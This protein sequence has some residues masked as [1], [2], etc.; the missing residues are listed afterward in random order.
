MRADP[1]FKAVVAGAAIPKADVKATTAAVDAAFG[2]ASDLTPFI[3]PLRPVR[4]IIK[5]SLTGDT[6]TTAVDGH[7]LSA[8]FKTL[9]QEGVPALNGMEGMTCDA[10]CCTSDEHML[11]HNNLFLQKVCLEADGAGWATLRSI[12]I[13]DGQ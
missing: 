9:S 7:T 8:H 4:V 10:T 6:T 13:I 5:G 1:A 3:D 2:G 11:A 12:E